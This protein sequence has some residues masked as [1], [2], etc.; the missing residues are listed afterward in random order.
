VTVPTLTLP[1][2]DDLPA[3]GLGT[4]DLDDETVRGSVHTALDAGYTHIDTAEGYHNEAAIGEAIAEY[5]RED[6]FL[7]SKVLPKHLGY[8]SLIEACEASLDR[9]GTDYLDLYLVHWPNPMVPLRETLDAMALL[10]ERGNV[11]NV[12]VSNFDAYRLSAAQHVSDV[13]VAVNQIECHPGF[14]R[15]ELIEYCQDNGIAVEAAAPLARTEL[16]GTETVEDLAE[17]YGKTPA[18]VILRWA[19]EKDVIVLPKSGS[20]VHVRENLELFDWEL[21]PADHERLDDCDRHEPVYDT[22]T[23]DWTDETYGISP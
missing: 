16:F 14:Y 5:D 11:R 19:V 6:V 15:P 13:P 20:P 3:V 17:T 22:L 23:R 9:L 10:H 8:E 1:S 7:T 18:Q 21:D 12:G 2:G 4:W